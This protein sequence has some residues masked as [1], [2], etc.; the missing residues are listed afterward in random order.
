MPII[1][2]YELPPVGSELFQDSESYLHELS[3][4]DIEL[5]A[6]SGRN[7]LI[8]SVIQS[9]AVNSQVTISQGISIQS[10]SLVTNSLVTNSLP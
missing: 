3:N 5:I 2:I 6:G 1:K 8:T 4:Q 9:V 7:I 10:I